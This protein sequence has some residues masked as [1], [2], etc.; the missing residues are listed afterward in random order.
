[1]KK[2]RR[3]GPVNQPFSRSFFLPQEPGL[4]PL[5]LCFSPPLGKLFIE[6]LALLFIKESCE[7]LGCIFALRALLKKGLL[8]LAQLTRLFLICRIAS[9]LEGFAPLLNFIVMVAAP[10]VRR[11]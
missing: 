9:R 6:P 7:L 1:M 8:F 3:S 2:V 10:F 4:L 11:H 5:H